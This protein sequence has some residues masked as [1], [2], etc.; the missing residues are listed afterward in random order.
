MSEIIVSRPLRGEVIAP[1]SKSYAHRLLICAALSKAPSTILCGRYCDDIMSTVRCLEALGARFNGNTVIPA[2]RAAL[3][4]SPVLNCGES[5]STL[6]FLMPIVAALGCG[7]EFEVGGGLASRPVEALAEEL[8]RHGAAVTGNRVSGKLRGNEFNIPG[9]ISS[10]YVSGLLMA[11]PLLGGGSVNITTDIQSSN[12]IEITID[13]LQRANVYVNQIGSRFEVSGEYS[14]CGAQTVEADWSSAAFW[15]CAGAI[16]AH[17]VTVSRLNPLSIQSDRQIVQILHQFG[18]DVK[19]IPNGTVTV[20]P[21]R[22]HSMDIDA[23]EIPDL[24]PVLSVVCAAAEGESRIY[25]A[26]RLRYKES[27]RLHAISVMLTELGA[28]VTELPDG[29]IIRG[30]RKLHGGKV[31]SFSDHRIAMSAAVASLICTGD[32]EIDDLS[33]VSKSYPDFRRDFISLGGVINEQI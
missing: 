29:L 25:N 30:R 13:C 31:Q 8:N 17:P 1:P 10:Q 23:A 3:P 26:S 21:A 15:L 11:L 4:H 28:D 32:I 9:N 7:A 27:D 16:G 24:I 14:L 18:A 33:C 2:D 6:R 22:L 12:Y 19:C 5:G 20:S